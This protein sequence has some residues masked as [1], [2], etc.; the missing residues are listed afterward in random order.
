MPTWIDPEHGHRVELFDDADVSAADAISL[1][2]ADAGLPEVEARRRV[3]E[4]THVATDGHGALIGMSTTFL[5]RYGPLDLPFWHFRAFVS[6]AHRR[7]RVA[8]VFLAEGFLHLH[9]RASR[10]EIAGAGMLVVAEDEQLRRGQPQAMWPRTRFAYVADNIHGWPIRVRYFDG[11]SVPDRAGSL[12]SAEPVPSAPMG[13]HR[14]EAVRGALDD[15]RRSQI[16]DLWS[17]HRVLEGAPAEQRLEHVIAVL[18]DDADRVI[19]VNTAIAERVGLLGGRRFW[20]YRRFLEPAAS[21]DDHMAMLTVAY[22]V[23]AAEFDTDPTGPIGVCA[24]LGDR[25][26]LA[27]NREA[28]WANGFLY[29]GYLPDDRQVRVRYF[30][31]ASIFQ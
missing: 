17:R 29:A 21:D 30:E 11:A 25:D 2:T 16:L 1:W 22:E 31:G 26:F 4:L 28:V 3:R 7:S 23:L 5:A 10:G 18:V 20:V 15:G 27:R 13:S 8:I 9:G 19:G 12:V 14:V 24:L 6:E